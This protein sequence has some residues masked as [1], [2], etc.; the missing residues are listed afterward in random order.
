MSDP[1]RARLAAMRCDA[2]ARNAETAAARYPVGGIFHTDYL[3]IAADARDNAAEWR[4]VL[5]RLEA[6]RGPCEFCDADRDGGCQ[7]G[8]HCGPCEVARAED[9]DADARFDAYA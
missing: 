9:E 1:T 6:D 3:A 5:A 8:C 4:A 7:D 2:I